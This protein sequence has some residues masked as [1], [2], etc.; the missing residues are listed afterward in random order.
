MHS[1]I[2]LITLV[3]S[4]IIL[5]AVNYNEYDELPCEYLDSINITGGTLQADE[6]IVFNGITFTN[7]QYTRVDF[8]LKNGQTRETVKPYYRGCV[9]NRKSCV[10]LCCPLGSFYKN[11][12]CQ[13][14]H[15]V[16]HLKTQ[17]LDEVHMQTKSMILD[18]HFAY[19]NDRPCNQRYLADPTFQITHVKYPIR[20]DYA[21]SV[22]FL[23]TLFNLFL[24]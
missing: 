11:G 8:I 15:Q 4:M 6:S 17:V 12:S 10:R 13:S 9:C 20:S 21:K 18:N 2:Y 16:R 3:I 14:H 24:P 1:I 22:L 7:D 5:F 23:M 19:V